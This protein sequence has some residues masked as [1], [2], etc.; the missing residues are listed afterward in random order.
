V[1]LKGPH[2][3]PGFTSP[4]SAA[5]RKRRD[6]V[7]IAATGHRAPPAAVRAGG[8]VEKQPALR[9]GTC[10]EAGVAALGDNVCA[11]SRNRG[12][13]PFEAAFPRDKLALPL[14]LLLHKLVVTLRNAKDLVD[15]FNGGMTRNLFANHRAKAFTEGS[16]KTVCSAEKRVGS[17]RVRAGKGEQLSA[18]PGGDNAT[19]EKEV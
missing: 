4:G 7:A 16:A 18:A 8:I 19:Q 11:R 17:G 13:K 9:V 6:F 15:G 5:P 10:A 14:P 1:D 2:P 3:F 12:K